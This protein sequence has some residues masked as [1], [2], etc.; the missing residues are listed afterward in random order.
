MTLNLN[1][2]LDCVDGDLIVEGSKKFLNGISIDTRKISDEQIFLAIS[3]KNFDGNK[4]VI[5]AIK[6]NVKLCFNNIC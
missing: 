6:K 1:E 2:I 5:D 3:G 4:Y